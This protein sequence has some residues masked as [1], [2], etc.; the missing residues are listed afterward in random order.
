[1]PCAEY[2]N[3]STLLQDR[4][5][6]HFGALCKIPHPSFG[7]RQISDYLLQWARGL[8]LDAHQDQR[9]NVVIKKPASPG[10][11]QAPTVILQA[12]MDMVCEKAPGVQHDFAADPIHLELDGD[13]L[14]T[15]GRTT[16][17]AD[18]GIGVAYIMAILEDSSAV[19][20]PLE[21]VITTAEEEDL[22]GAL[23]LDASTLCG[24]LLINIDNAV[25]HELLSGSCGGIGVELALPI[26]YAALPDNYSAFELLLSGLP[27][28]HSGEDIRN[29]HGN[30]IQLLGRLLHGLQGALPLAVAD[31]SGGNF[32]LAIPREA[33]AVILVP[34]ESESNVCAMVEQMQRLFTKEYRV[35]APKLRVE[36]RPCAKPERVLSA[37]S[38]LRLI[39]AL[40]LSPNGILEMDSAVPGVVSSSDNFGELRLV[41]DQAV[42]VFEIR[43]AHE[44]ARDYIHQKLEVLAELLGGQCRGFAAYPGWA[45]N[46]DSRLRTLAQAVYQNEF[47]EEI[48]PVTVHAGLECGCF[49]PKIPGLDAISI[50]PDTWGL[51]SP[52]ERLSVSSTQRVYRYIKALL[53][54]CRELP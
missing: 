14:S 13:T 50:G 18:D 43:A 35:V 38:L 19:H 46:P 32:R 20:P 54:A 27:G 22:S 25:E 21:A 29:G 12:H 4:V 49:F 23:E 17:G 36:L 51:H 28:G 30:A 47:G 42:L 2:Q 48:R 11:E 9:W 5:F 1:M 45:Y 31:F 52:S 8:G 6:H 24:R 33:R 15:G 41:K 10:Y 37:P 26:E 40:Y 7:E 34:T 16:L 39:Q 53:V 44:S 3:L